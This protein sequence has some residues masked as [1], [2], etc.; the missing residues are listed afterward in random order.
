MPG[1]EGEE[2]V[3]VEETMQKM[4]PALP[5]S[6]HRIS[7]QHRFPFRMQCRMAYYTMVKI[8]YKNWHGLRI[9]GR[10]MKSPYLPFR[11]PMRIILPSTSDQMHEQLSL[12]HQWQGWQLQDLG[13]LGVRL[14]LSAGDRGH[15]RLHA[16]DPARPYPC[17]N[18]WDPLHR[19]VRSP[20]GA[21]RREAR[22][23]VPS[24]RRAVMGPRAS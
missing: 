8:L 14:A 2:I 3:P 1:E 21:A 5:R 6:I 7:D 4:D 13:D 11:D 22:W 16:A 17:R 19:V 9:S 12:P 24:A 15:F 20:Q 10:M 23:A 18:R